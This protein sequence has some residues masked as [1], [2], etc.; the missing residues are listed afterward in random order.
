[1]RVISLFPAIALVAGCST[2]H[3]RPLNPSSTAA[4]FEGR[5]LNNSGLKEYLEKH[6]HHPITPWPPASWDLTMLT[7][8]AFY[9]H[10]S[11]D[12]ARAAWEEKEAAVTTAGGRPNPGAGFTPQYHANPGGLAPWTLTFFLN[13]PV[14]TAGKRAYRIAGAKH[15]SAAARMDIADAAWK[16][17]SRLRRDLLSLYGLIQ[18]ERILQEELSLQE[19]VVRIYRERLAAGEDSRFALTTSLIAL[20][21]TTLSLSRTRKDEVQARVDLAASMGIP[22]DALRGIDISFRSMAKVDAGLYSEEIRREAL[23]NRADILAKLAE[24]EAAQA[25]LRLEIA[26][27]YPDVHLGPAYAWDQGD[28]EWSLGAALTLPVF[29]RN[30][31][32]IAEARARRKEKAAEFIALQA[33]VIED[34]D[35]AFDGYNASLKVLET[36]DSLLSRQKKKIEAAK[37]RFGSGQTDSLALMEAGQEL[38]SVRL[39]RLEALIMAQTA[40]GSLEDAVQRPLNSMD[41]LPPDS[42]PGKA[43]R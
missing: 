26:R 24:Y 6:L 10:P 16:V 3:A 25:S 17:R 38:I 34:A 2:F 29:N 31:G 1:M 8:T 40:V 43:E 30:Q 19:R 39:S 22:V 32:P 27:Q 7:L 12:I 20:D 11:L 4:A 41:A 33:R 15:L 23:L 18:R 9:Y 28:N 42:M 37:A 21:K 36:A 13:I 14:E 35:R 5:S